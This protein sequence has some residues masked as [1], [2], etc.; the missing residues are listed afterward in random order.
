MAIIFK[1]L[2]G[3][4]SQISCR[5]GRGGGEKIYINDPSH[6]TKMAT[7]PIYRKTVKI[8][9]SRTESPMILKLAMQ[10]RGLKLN[11]VDINEDPGLSLT[12]ITAMS[13]FV[14]YTTV[15]K[16]FNGKNLQ[17]ITYEN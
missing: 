15:T 17:Q 5:R 16:S 8:F 12:Y 14:A 3:H 4:Q 1:Q 2:L 10:Y 9:F 6:M 13:N 7:M 11:K